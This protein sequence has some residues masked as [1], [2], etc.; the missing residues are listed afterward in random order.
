MN[1]R[2]IALALLASGALAAGPDIAVYYFPQWHA[3][4]QNEARFGPGWSEWKLVPAARPRFPGHRQPLVPAWGAEN[5]ADPAVMARKIDIAAAH[6]I[7]AFVFDWYFNAAGP[8]LHRA[9]EEGFLAATNAAAL[10][11]AVMWANHD[12]HSGPGAVAEEIFVRATDRMI[13][14]YFPRTNYWRVG[15]GMY[16]SIYEADTLAA[17]LGGPAAAA[18]VLRGFRERVRAAGL[19]ELHLNA[20]AQSRSQPDTVRALGFDSVGSYHWIH[21]LGIQDFPAMD[22]ATYRGRAVPL[23]RQVPARYGLPH[24]PVAVMG[25]D[26]SPRTPQDQPFVPGG[27]PWGAVLT[28]NPPAEFRRTLEQARGWVEAAT[29]QPPVLLIEAWNEWTEGS[30]L[31]PDTLQGYGYLEAVRA[32]F[33]AGGP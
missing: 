6:G 10:K 32:V 7:D 29:H 17:G 22:Y 21:Y 8:F 25:W 3:D 28:N 24:F 20:I 26:S 4:P 30:Y 11:F 14:R 13:E 33:G 27:Y 12:L 2:A 15:G 18:A 5:E 31:E 23:M 9:L 1:P 16:V 19:G